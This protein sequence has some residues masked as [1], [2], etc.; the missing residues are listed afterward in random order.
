MRKV[1]ALCALVLTLLLTG[2]SGAEEENIV[3]IGERFFV[4]RINDILFTNT[5]DYIGRT[6]RYEGMFWTVYWEPTGRDHF[7]V[8]RYT[9][10]CCGDH[11]SSIGF[12]LRLNGARSLP[13]DTWVE[14]T[15]VLE[16]ADDGIQHVRLRVVSLRELDERGLE[17]VDS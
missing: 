12:E 8:I 6:I 13:D 7:Y 3:E 9:D 5:R 14:V 15:G 17:F 2:C 16:E 11:D 10:G 4:T 1:L